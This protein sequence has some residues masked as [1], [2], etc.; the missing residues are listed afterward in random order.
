MKGISSK[1]VYLTQV[2]IGET[3]LWCIIVD[4]N[5]RPFVPKEWRKLVATT[6][7]QLNHQGPDITAKNV[8]QYYWPNLL[9]DVKTWTK[10]CIA[11]QSVKVAKSIKPPMDHRP[12]GG[13][14]TDVQCGG[15]PPAAVKGH[16]P[17]PHRL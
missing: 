2:S 4:G 7:H 14:F 11:C 1:K 15:G 12:V 16:D 8:H 3:L 10:T 9:K 5:P 6:F 13:W 17:P